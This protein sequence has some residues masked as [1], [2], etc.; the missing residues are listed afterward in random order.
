MYLYLS[1]L[2]MAFRGQTFT[3]CCHRTFLLH[4][5]IKGTFKDHLATWVT[6]YIKLEH[7]PA[8]AKRILAQIDQRYVPLSGS[9][10]YLSFLFESSALLRIHLSLVSVVSQKV[11]DSSNGR[12]MTP[13]LS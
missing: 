3:N 11:G 12:E 4:Q 13:K 9:V 8:A 7:S 5:I 10:G 2:R 6:D 1:H